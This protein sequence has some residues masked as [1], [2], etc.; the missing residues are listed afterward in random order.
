MAPLMQRERVPVYLVIGRIS[1]VFG[2]SVAL[3][4]A[5]FFLIGGL[6]LPALIAL[7]LALPFAALM[8]LV[9]TLATRTRSR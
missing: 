8:P 4:S 2:L 1:A 5:I 3:A 9:E 6:F 7:L